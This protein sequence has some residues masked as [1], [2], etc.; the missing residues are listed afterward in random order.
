MPMAELTIEFRARLRVPNNDEWKMLRRRARKAARELVTLA[1]AGDGAQGD[2]HHLADVV[3]A[4][5]SL[6]QTLRRMRATNRE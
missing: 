5:E 2:I 6:A 4:M 1:R 3:E